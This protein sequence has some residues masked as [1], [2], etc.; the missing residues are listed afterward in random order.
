MYCRTC[1]YD[2]AGLE[3][4]RCPECGRGFDRADPRSYRRRRPG[5]PW[6]VGI[7]F[8]ILIGIIA[9]SGF[10]AALLPNYGDSRH[11]AFAFV[12]GIGLIGGVTSA[13]LAAANRSWLGRAPLLLVGVLCVWFGL[14]LGSEKYFR[15]WQ[16]MPDPPDEAFADTA[17]LGALLAGWMPGLI[18][19]AFA[20]AVSLVVVIAIGGRA[21]RERT[22]A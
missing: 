11:A 22:H 21:H 7:G 5:P 14:F 9:A 3:A 17:P 6:V 12:L 15:V 1:V 18:V 10:W 19:V 13:A 20:Y 2:L 4:G 16:S 8:A